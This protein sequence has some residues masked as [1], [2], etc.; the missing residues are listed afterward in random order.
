MEAAAATS[1]ISTIASTHFSLSNLKIQK[2]AVKEANKAAKQQAELDRQNIQNTLAEH[3]RK[4]LNLLAQQQ[5]AYRAK[6]GASNLSA[7]SGSGQV[8]LDAM[9]KEH[10]IEDKYVQSQ[11]NIS[12]DA[13]KNSIEKV[14]T[15]NLL[16]LR[17]LTNDQGATI[18]NSV[19]SLS[20]SMIK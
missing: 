20:N 15:Q 9:Q 3:Q 5:S 8:V 17:S 11:A 12:L 10:D 1:I 18:A 16:R 7:N 19:T 13:L 14:N 6:L 4:S 2:K